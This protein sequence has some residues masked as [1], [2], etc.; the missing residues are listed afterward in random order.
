M[1]T[2]LTQTKEM[3]FSITFLNRIP[4]NIKAKIP[5]Y[6]VLTMPLPG[7]S[8]LDFPIATENKQMKAG[9]GKKTSRRT[10]GKK[11][12]AKTYTPVKSLTLQGELK[13]GRN[14]RFCVN[15]IEFACD[16]TAF[17]VGEPQIGKTA[18]VTLKRTKTGGWKAAS[19]CVE[20]AY[21]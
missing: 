19:V 13:A 21:S 11:V 3:D 16:E 6:S 15:E 14:A 1:T 17:V 4:D 9:A 8:F 5:G 20:S 12:K 2:D 18:K 10:T 7:L